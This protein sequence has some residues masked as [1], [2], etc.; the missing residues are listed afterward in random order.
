MTAL[1]SELRLL[2][3]SDDL[4]KSKRGCRTINDAMIARETQW[5]HLA[6]H[7]LSVLHN[8]AIAHAADRKDSDLGRVDDWSCEASSV[9][10][11][12]RDRKC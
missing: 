9:A 5:H 3:E 12:I 1:E 10:A 11:H 6:D 2:Q 7:R 8:N 4:R